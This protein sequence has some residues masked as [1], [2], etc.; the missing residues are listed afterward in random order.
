MKIITLLYFLLLLQKN[1]FSQT[2]SSITRNYDFKPI[3]VVLLVDNCVVYDTAASNNFLERYHDKFRKQK[4]YGVK[5]AKLKFGIV[6]K[7][8]VLQCYLKNGVVLDSVILKYCVPLP[9]K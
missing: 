7:D 4:A 6:S 1:G 3:E 5:K 8:G 9:S 2:D